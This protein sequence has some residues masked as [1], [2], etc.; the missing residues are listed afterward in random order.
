MIKLSGKDVTFGENTI[1]QSGQRLLTKSGIREHSLSGK[2]KTGFHWNGH[3][4]PPPEAGC[5]LYLPGYPAQGSILQDF[6]GQGNN[7]TITG[8]T[9]ERL[10]SGLWVQYFDGTDDYVNCGAVIALGE[11]TFKFW[12]KSG[13]SAGNVGIIG[14]NGV[15]DSIGFSLIGTAPLLLLAGSNYQYFVDIS[16]YLD[17]KWHLCFLYIAGSGLNDIDSC[18]LQIDS[19]NIAKDGAP[20]KTG[21]PDVWGSLIWGRNSYGFINTYLGQ[22]QVVSGSV[23]APVRV[24]SFVQ[25]RHLF[26]V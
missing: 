11:C 2:R 26:G 4:F 6:S 9:W 24:N 22:E 12:F 25:E 21:S 19:N 17:S 13:H 7:G 5:V 3:R 8:A 18:S 1:S 16:A 15:A 20:V 10:P 23:A 14:F